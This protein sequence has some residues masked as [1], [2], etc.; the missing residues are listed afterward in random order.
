M[1]GET[2][3]SFERLYDLLEHVLDPKHK[4][5]K[6]S[7]G[8]KDKLLVLLFFYRHY[9]GTQELFIT[10][11]LPSLGAT[12]KLI[13]ELS[14]DIHDVLVEQFLPVPSVQELALTLKEGDPFPDSLLVV[15]STFQPTNKP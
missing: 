8:P 1:T 14:R 9:P 3:A 2:I 13:T 10:F 15:D 5:R 7:I 4:G 12:S 11:R 6:D